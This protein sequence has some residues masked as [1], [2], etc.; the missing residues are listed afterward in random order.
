[1]LKKAT[2][3]MTEDSPELIMFRKAFKYTEIESVMYALLKL[4]KQDT[5]ISFRKGSDAAVIVNEMRNM[6]TAFYNGSVK[7]SGSKA[8]TTRLNVLAQYATSVGIKSPMVAVDYL[9]KK[10]KTKSNYMHDVLMD[11]IAEIEW[12]T[13]TGEAEIAIDSIWLNGMIPPY[14]WRQAAIRKMLREITLN[15]RFKMPTAADLQF[16]AFNND[17]N[18]VKCTPSSGIANKTSNVLTPASD[19]KAAYIKENCKHK[20][21]PTSAVAPNAIYLAILTPI[22]LP[23]STQVYVGKAD[24]GTIDRWDSSASSH[25]KAIQS[26][27]S[28]VQQHAGVLIEASLVELELAALWCCEPT[29]WKDVVICTL[30]SDNYKSKVAGE[31][32]ETFYMDQYGSTSQRLGMNQKR[33]AAKAANA[34][35]TS[36]ADAHDDDDD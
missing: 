20:S 26:V 7:Y 15:E 6:I 31:E 14:T 24:N 18:A 4:R 8:C 12:D 10:S 16:Y 22:D 11:N 29:Q 1:M 2:E 19:A 21:Q 23:L 25:L 27:I 30:E 35:A 5:K 34:D 32:R 36:G 3:G 33:S 13:T 9:Q 17:G 28:C